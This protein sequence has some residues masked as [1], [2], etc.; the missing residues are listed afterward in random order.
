MGKKIMK[1]VIQ[2]FW[3]PL[4]QKK[5]GKLWDSQMGKIDNHE[6]NVQGQLYGTIIANYRCTRIFHH[7]IT[8]ETLTI[9]FVVVSRVYIS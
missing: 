3:A 8:V 4:E 2:G 7:I 9:V 1:N 5:I 6:N